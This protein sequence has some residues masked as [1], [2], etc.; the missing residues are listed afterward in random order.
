VAKITLIGAG[1]TGFSKRFISDILTRPAL[2]EGTL[3]LMD[4]NQD[5]LDTDGVDF[6]L[7]WTFESGGN[8]FG[9]GFQGTKTLTYDLTSEDRVFR[10]VGSH[11]SSNL[12]PPAPEWMGIARFDWRRGDHY[13]RATL[14]H[15]PSLFEDAPAA[16]GITEEFA[17]TTL[18]LLYN[19]I[20]PGGSGT[21][22]AG[23]IN[24][25]DEEIPRK[26][27]T[28]LTA[29]TLVHDPRGRMFRVGANWGF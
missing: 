6:D 13:A 16:Q 22:T 28:F 21:F 7:N 27:Q 12:G 15:I 29:N 18:D 11:N 19:Y 17:Y 14:R 1:S 9:L 2:A 5:Y 10:G 26:G 3:S 24:V 8:E 4:I 20:L 23:V 25:A